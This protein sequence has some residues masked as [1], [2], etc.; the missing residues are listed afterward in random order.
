MSDIANSSWPSAGVVIPTFNGAERLPKVL[1]ALAMQSTPDRSFEVVLVDNAST[2]GTASVAELDPSTRRLRERGIQVRVIAEPNQGLIHARIAGVKGTRADVV[3]FLDDDNIPDRDFVANGIPLFSQGSLGLAISSVRPSWEVLPPPSVERRKHLLAVNDYL[4]DQVLDFGATATPAPTIGAGMWVRRSAFISAVPCDQ[5]E[6]LLPGRV[7]RRL[8]SGEDIE[9]GILIGRAGYNRIYVPTL[10]LVH[11]IPR[12]RLET[13]Y[14][15]E[16]IT[17][18]IRSELTLREKY[19]G[20]KFNSRVRLIG[21]LRLSAAVCAIPWLAAM[22]SDSRRE[23]A[24]VI[25]A[26]RA[27][28]RGPLR[29][30]E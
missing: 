15:C 22:R 24:F 29:L 8:A 13:A 10:R 28:L 20:T 16:L 26:R 30:G 27:I 12:R 19:G 18:I 17:G 14:I 25:A 2:D 3:C 23:I 11:E 1:A 9:L 5:P 4:G 6:L 21:L 7:G